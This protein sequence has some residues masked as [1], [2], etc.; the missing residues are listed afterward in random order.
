MLKL[1]NVSFGYNEDLV[2]KK[3]SLNIAE[4]DHISLIGESGCGKS[5]L[6]QLIYGLHDTNGLISWKQKELRG[7]K[8]NLVPG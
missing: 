8:F 4:G 7:P 6:L 1:K 3:I 5:T 2:L